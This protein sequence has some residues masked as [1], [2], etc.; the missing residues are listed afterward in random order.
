MYSSMI[1]KRFHYNTYLKKLH[2]FSDFIYFI[3]ILSDTI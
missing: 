1:L 2:L 3:T